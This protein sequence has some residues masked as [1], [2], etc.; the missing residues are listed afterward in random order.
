MSI[1]KLLEVIAT[2]PRR[3]Y[4]PGTNL[5]SYSLSAMQYLEVVPSCESSRS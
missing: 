3:F 2:T 1:G 4:L 5:S